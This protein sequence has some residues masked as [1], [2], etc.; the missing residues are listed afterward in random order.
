M[1]LHK[2]DPVCSFCEFHHFR[3]TEEIPGA[4]VVARVTEIDQHDM[5]SEDEADP[6]QTIPTFSKEEFKNLDL[7]E[8]ADEFYYQLLQE[9]SNLS[10]EV[11]IIEGGSHLIT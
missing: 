3:L 1:T 9:A 8:E 11:T 10:T 4:R 6:V 2:D 7:T 5:S